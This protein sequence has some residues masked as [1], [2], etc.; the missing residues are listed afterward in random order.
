MKLIDVR[1]LQGMRCLSLYPHWAWC[2]F[3]GGKDIEN[4]EWSVE[5]VDFPFN[6]AI[7]GGKNVKD[8]DDDAVIIREQHGV[9]LPAKDLIPK[10]VIYGVVEVTGITRRSISRWAARDC[11][12]W[13][14]RNPRVLETPLPFRG[15]QKI[16]QVRLYENSMEMSR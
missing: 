9:I 3:H 1:E 16:F 10:G 7:H 6:L 12:Q 15:Y 11:F 4:R 14:L 2:V 8:Y 5:G 13:E